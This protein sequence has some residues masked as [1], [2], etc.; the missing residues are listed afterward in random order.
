MANI[1]RYTS[2]TQEL[3]VEGIDLTNAEIYVS[4]RQKCVSLVFSGDDLQVEAVTEDERTD[5]KIS[6]HMSQEMTAKFRADEDVEVQVNWILDGQ[7]NATI[8]AKFG[9]QRNLLEAV[10]ES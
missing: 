1:R 3:I 2:P 4:Y 5:T 8:I 9:I 7:R 6:V 10:I